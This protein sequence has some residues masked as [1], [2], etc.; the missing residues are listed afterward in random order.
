MLIIFDPGLFLRTT[1]PSKGGLSPQKCYSG[2]I[3]YPEKLPV[4]LISENLF[5]L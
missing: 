4:L 5:A 3:G 1:V 2:G